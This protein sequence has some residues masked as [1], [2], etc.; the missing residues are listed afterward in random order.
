MKILKVAVIALEKIGFCT[1]AVGAGA[2]LACLDLDDL[3]PVQLAPDG[4][5]PEHCSTYTSLTG[6]TGTACYWAFPLRDDNAITFSG[7][8]VARIKDCRG[9]VFVPSEDGV[10]HPD[11][12]ALE[13]LRTEAN[14]FWVA[15]KDKIG[16][17]R[18]LVVL[19]QEPR[20]N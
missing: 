8:I 12:Y 16:Q 11:S 4:T 14:L 13:H 9:A 19:R 2:A 1:L 5:S 15:I 3:N 18:T 17:N 10:N 6:A 20:T 7:R